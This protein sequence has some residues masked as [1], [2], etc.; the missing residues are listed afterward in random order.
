MMA[1]SNANNNHDNTVDLI[2]NN[3]MWQMTYNIIKKN[4]KS[5]DFCNA[6]YQYSI[7]QIIN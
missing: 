7:I 5:R 3:T 6:Q 4:R 1:N 2:N